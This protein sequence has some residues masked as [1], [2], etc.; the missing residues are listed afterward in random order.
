MT[1]V[2]IDRHPLLQYYSSVGALLFFAL[3]LIL[4]DGYSYGALL[5]LLAGLSCLFIRGTYR[6]LSSGH[7]VFLFALIFYALIWMAE[8]YFHNLG[9]RE[10]DRPSRFLAAAIA[11]IFLMRHPPLPHFVWFG[12]TFGALATGALALWEKLALGIARVDGFTNAIQYGNLSALLG[13]LCLVGIAWAVKQEQ[14][15]QLWLLLL[16]LGFISGL[17]ASL[18]SGSRGGW[19]G[20][21]FI[22]L[23]I[24]SFFRSIFSIKAILTGFLSIVLLGLLA[25]VVPSSGVKMR[26]DQ[27]F[28]E[29][30][31]Y[32]Q[33][34]TLTS[35]GT[36]L[37]LW[38]GNLKLISEKPVLGWGE[39]GY[40]Q[41]LKEL[42]DTG[43]INP[44]ILGHAHNDLLD[45]MSRRGVFGLI[46]LLLLYGLP[47][48]LF[49]RQ[50][51]FYGEPIALAGAV[52]VFCFIDF[53]LT[54]VFFAHNS[55]VMM[56]GFSI[57]ILYAAAQGAI[58][59]N[60]RVKS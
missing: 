21:P 1:V 52:T 31:Q 43:Y 57:V 49:T 10:Y 53:G 46:S 12:I 16:I 17:A 35:V 7:Q 24:A 51:R 37:E 11:L 4:P 38:K 14:Y 30:G 41:R 5:L 29:L 6:Q 40:D 19:I 50:A 32:S 48:Y 8:V 13:I 26:V 18:L 25:Y 36:R 20:L 59:T 56:Y 2:T 39:Y 58:S 9:T 55:G 44:A 42:R 60:L 27:V 47:L 45:V 22:L 28:S 23:F 54:Q 15:R 34:K 33:G 3:S